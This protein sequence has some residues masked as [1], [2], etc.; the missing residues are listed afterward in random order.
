MITFT[1]HIKHCLLTC[2]FWGQIRINMLIRWLHNV[3]GLKGQLTRWLEQLSSFPCRHLHCPWR[4]NTTVEASVWSW[5]YMIVDWWEV[6][7]QNKMHPM[8]PKYHELKVLHSFHNSVSL[9]YFYWLGWLELWNM[10]LYPTS[11]DSGIQALSTCGFEYS[12]TTSWNSRKRNFGKVNIIFSNRQCLGIN[13]A[14]VN[15]GDLRLYT[16]AWAKNSFKFVGR[17]FVSL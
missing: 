3:Q 9:D 17:K 6:R 2:S 5:S 11:I 10:V 16:L 14:F 8:Y 13:L 15:L 4:V 7:L 1:K 12:R